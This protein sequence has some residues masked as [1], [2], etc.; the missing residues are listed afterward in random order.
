MTAPSPLTSQEMR[1]LSGNP[2]YANCVVL[3]PWGYEFQVYDDGVWSIWMLCIKPGQGT[4]IHCHTTKK[5]VFIPLEGQLSCKIQEGEIDLNF[6]ESM[7]VDRYCFHS[8]R[9][10]TNKHIYLLEAETPSQKVDLIRLND[11]YGRVGQGYERDVIREDLSIYDHF[12]LKSGASHRWRDFAI[13]II[14]GELVV[15]TPEPDA[16]LFRMPL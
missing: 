12:S 6:P 15:S 7:E 8:V 16:P 11:K 5:A 3:K 13:G 9:N 4:S 2:D 14:E 1:P 10:N